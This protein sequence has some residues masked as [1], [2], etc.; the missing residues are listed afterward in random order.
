MSSLRATSIT[1]HGPFT[2]V[3]LRMP[4]VGVDRTYFSL[5][6]SSP[7]WMKNKYGQTL[8]RTAVLFRLDATGPLLIFIPDL[9]TEA[10]KKDGQHL[11]GASV[12]YDFTSIQHLSLKSLI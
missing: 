5:Y 7:I 2:E 11:T 1:N 3:E 8:Q 4:I 10:P 12:F 6:Y 9:A